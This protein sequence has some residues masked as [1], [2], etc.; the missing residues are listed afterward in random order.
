MNIISILKRPKFNKINQLFT[1][2]WYWMT[3]QSRLKRK[4]KKDF[5]KSFKSSIKLRRIN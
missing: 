3:N 5:N 2:D 1:F 4:I